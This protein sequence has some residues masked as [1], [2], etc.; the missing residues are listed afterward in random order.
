MTEKFKAKISNLSTKFKGKH[1][2][3][4][5]NIKVFH[6]AGHK[7]TRKEINEYATKMSKKLG[8]KYSIEV[9]AKYGSRWFN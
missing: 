3:D 8:D 5:T 7:Y 4:R 1:K 2:V 6:Y 9:N